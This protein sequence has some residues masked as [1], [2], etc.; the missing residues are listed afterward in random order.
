MMVESPIIKAHQPCINPE[1]G[2]SNA[3][4]IREN[5]SAF[6]FS[7]NKNFKQGDVNDNSISPQRQDNPMVNDTVGQFRSQL[8]DIALYKSY[9]LGSRKISRDVVDAFNVRMSVNEDGKPEAH[10]YPYTR[11]GK[12]VAY[13]VRQL[14]KDFRVVGDFK[15]VELF[16]QS[17]AGNGKYLVI[18][19]G[20]IDA[21]AVAQAY[22]EKYGRIYPVVSV[23]SA[24][25]LK[26]L[27]EQ[28]DWIKQFKEVII[29]FDQDDAG[30]RAIDEAAKIIGQGRAK[31]ARL[32]EKDASDELV[33]HGGKA[34]LDAIWNAQTWS[35]AGIVMGEQI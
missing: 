25:N 3:M 11:E 27:L 20:E 1:C 2:S 15:K 21:M 34:I 31:V 16:G 19:E 12:T 9:P 30:E 7:C 29:L 28:R 6:C 22:L 18:T 32:K 4:S 33:K 23:P 17:H 10:Y 24:S 13:K 5:G 14:P 26:V 8:S 35:P